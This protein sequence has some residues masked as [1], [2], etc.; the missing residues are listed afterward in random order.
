MIRTPKATRTMVKG[1]PSLPVLLSC[2]VQCIA[3][4]GLHGLWDSHNFPRGR[5]MF[6]FRLKKP[7][8]QV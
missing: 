6:L 5:R 2:L 4:S 8:F 1:A 3:L 7:H